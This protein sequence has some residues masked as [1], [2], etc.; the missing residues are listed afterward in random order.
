MPGK[1]K[2][3]PDTAG[4][5]TAVAPLV[6]RWMERLLAGSPRRLTVSQYLTLRAIARG[7]ISAADLSRRTGVSA[8]AVSQLVSS[9]ADGGLIDRIRVEGDRRRRLLLL[10]PSGESALEESGALLRQELGTLLAD[11]PKPE[12]DA[13]GRALP[14]LEAVLAGTPPPR[15]PRPPAKP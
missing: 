1:G 9:L 13:L 14:A 5:L 15:R 6:A 3:K 7:E 11:L 2:A 4:L 12:A 10:T 8:P